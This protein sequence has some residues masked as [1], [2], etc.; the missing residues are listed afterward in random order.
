MVTVSSSG[1]TT[2]S[3]VEA[4]ACVTQLSGTWVVSLL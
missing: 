3:S 4:K 2:A 1:D